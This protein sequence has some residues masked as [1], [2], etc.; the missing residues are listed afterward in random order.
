VVLDPRSAPVPSGPGAALAQ[1]RA[2]AAAERARALRIRLEAEPTQLNPL[3]DPER[4]ALWVIEDTI[5]ESLLRRVPTEDGGPARLAPGLAESYEVIPSG[6]EIRLHL[7]D[8]IKFHDGQPLGA[9]DVQ[10]TL[11]AVRGERS[12]APHLRAQLA[13]VVA[14]EMWGPRDVRLVL[15]RPDGYVLRALAEIPILPAHIYQSPDGRRGRNPVGTGPYRLERWSKGDRIVLGRNPDYWGAA[16]AIEEIEFLIEPDGA[17]S[18]VMAKQGELDV[19]PSMIPEHYP[20][21]ASAPGLAEAWRPLSL[22]PA[23]LRAVA[24]NARRAPFDDA[25]VRRAAAMVIDR[26]RLV[27]EVHRGLA[28]AIAGPIWPGGPGDGV[29]PEPPAFDPEAA[30]AL[31]DEAGW[32][33]EDHDGVR[34]RA[35]VKLRV[36]F[37]GGDDPLGDAER[38]VVIGGL[39]KA[40]FLVDV[41]PGDRSTQAARVAA[42]DFDAVVMEWRGRADESLASLLGTGGVVNL[43]G[44]S[45]AAVDAALAGLA[46]VWEPATRAPKLGELARLLITECPLLPLV[47]PDPHGLVHRRVHGLVVDD[48][49]FAIRALSLGREP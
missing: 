8:G 48:G 15:A 28:R 27:R 34:E 2:L 16:P 40:G 5:F 12:R 41:R 30:M 36:A 39:R 29:A 32:R 38:E 31:L 1:E 6:L 10:F 19:L 26:E 43:G 33:D 25:R 44:Y 21:Q 9:V 35:G 24:V 7:R 46:A 22:R 47:A 49:W 17:R 20:I 13:N 37:L 11:D 3:V 18:L 45:G 4:E 14:V 23:W 42:G